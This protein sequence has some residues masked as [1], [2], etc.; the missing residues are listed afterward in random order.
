MS[1]MGLK[2]V[3][4]DRKILAFCEALDA[5][6]IKESHYGWGCSWDRDQSAEAIPSGRVPVHARGR[7]TKPPHRPAA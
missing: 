6:F 4:D 2:P 1:L 3:R 7:A 5:Q